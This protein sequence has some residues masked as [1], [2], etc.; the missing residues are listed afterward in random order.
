MAHQRSRQ[1]F[2]SAGTVLPDRLPPV[3][4][5][6]TAPAMRQAARAGHRPF[7]TRFCG[8]CAG[9]SPSRGNPG[10]S[11]APMGGVFLPASTFPEGNAGGAP[12]FRF[13]RRL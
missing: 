3:S 8:Y 2:R 9:F 10:G 13:N 11:P 7:V 1:P 6:R 4:C 12:E 5:L